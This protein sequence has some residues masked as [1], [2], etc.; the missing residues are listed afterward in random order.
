MK[1]LFCLSMLQNCLEIL[2]FSWLA[3]HFNNVLK[4]KGI[5]FKTYLFIEFFFFLF[6]LDS[7]QMYKIFINRF[8]RKNFL[9]QSRN[10]FKSSSK[11]NIFA[12]T[13]QQC[14]WLFD[15]LVT[16]TWA[17]LTLK[18]LICTFILIIILSHNK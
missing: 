13:Y 12:I 7:L 10:K 5:F 9:E 6:P 14:R 4:I 8:Q 3:R 16:L 15:F 2:D 11:L 18:C 17:K 1:K